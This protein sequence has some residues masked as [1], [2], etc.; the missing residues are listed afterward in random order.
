MD[1]VKRNC[2]GVYRSQ[3]IT[4]RIKCRRPLSREC[5]KTPAYCFP[6][7][8]T[9]LPSASLEN[10]GI[11]GR[12]FSLSDS[13]LTGGGLGMIAIG[14]GGLDGRIHRSYLQVPKVVGVVDRKLQPWLSAKD[15]TRTRMLT[16]K[17]GLVKC[18]IF[19]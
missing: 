9:D 12:P 5:G 1:R 16:V 17:G 7:R 4:D 3:H 11:P 18:L 8:A 6:N 10:F 13:H 15:V 2:R 19:R 14:A